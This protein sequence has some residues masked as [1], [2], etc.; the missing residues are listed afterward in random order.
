MSV[1]EKAGSH[2]RV[3][4]VKA[5]SKEHYQISKLSIFLEIIRP[6]RLV[7]QFAESKVM[8]LMFKEVEQFVFLQHLIID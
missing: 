4:Q 1:E 5:G 8:H 3:G 6:D 2:V 7:Y